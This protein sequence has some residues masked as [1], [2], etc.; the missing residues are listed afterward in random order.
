VAVTLTL[1]DGTGT[2]VPG[3]KAFLSFTP[4]TGGGSA[5]VGSTALTT[6]P[7]Q[8]TADASGNIDITYSTPATLPDGGTDTLK[9]QNKAT[10]ANFNQSDIYRYRAT[11]LKRYK[12]TPYPIAK[13]ASLHT[14]QTVSLT[15][16]ALTSGGD[17][18]GGATI[19]L[20]KRGGVTLGTA[21]VGGTKLSK[22]PQPFTANGSGQVAVSFTAS[23]A[24][25]LP[26]T[27]TF[28]IVAQNAAT[29]PTV[30]ATD[31]YSYGKPAKYVF[32]PKPI[33][34]RGTLASGTSVVVTLTVKD[35][36]LNPV[37][38]A[39]VELIFHQAPGG[40]SATV[41][42]KALGSTASGFITDSKGRILVTY[43][44][45]ASPPSSGSD[46]LIAENT[47]TSPTITAKDGY[48]F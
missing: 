41:D 14:G 18:I 32:A 7:T 38:G 44:T 34:P 33:A 45:P 10:N 26:T 13:P 6:T 48:T 29:S 19:Y 15:V 40:G 24:A 37:A 46:K 3:G 2:P 43:T 39:R 5:S 9:A 8:F 20:S 17:G 47:T 1:E 11:V 28:T 30:T 27:G 22:T 35:A 36:S 4:T 23:Q 21:K 31:S 12:W 42:A 25:T 16:T